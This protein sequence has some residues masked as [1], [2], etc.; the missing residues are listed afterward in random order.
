MKYRITV[1]LIQNTREETVIDAYTKNEE[2]LTILITGIKT[3]LKNL[4]Y[5]CEEYPKNLTLCGT[6]NHTYK[7][8][9]TKTQNKP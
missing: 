5:D 2:H 3:M 8:K 4:G 1:D 6:P 7:I 9:L